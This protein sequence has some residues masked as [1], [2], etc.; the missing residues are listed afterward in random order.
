MNR[1]LIFKNEVSKDMA[2]KISEDFSKVVVGNMSENYMLKQ[3]IDEKGVVQFDQC[4]ID[5]L[6]DKVIRTI[7]NAGTSEFIF[8]CCNEYD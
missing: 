3:Y 8:I 4:N 6:K 7:L 5:C 2:V 1:T